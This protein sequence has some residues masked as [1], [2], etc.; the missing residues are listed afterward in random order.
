M[1]AAVLRTSTVEA[2]GAGMPSPSVMKG[3]P[4]SSVKVIAGPAPLQCVKNPSHAQGEDSTA[5]SVAYL[6]TG[7]NTS[8]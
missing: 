8:S 7:A 1:E 6:D 3:M 2:C 4:H 5:R